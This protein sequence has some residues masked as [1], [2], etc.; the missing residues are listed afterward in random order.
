MGQASSLVLRDVHLAL[1]SVVEEAYGH[2]RTPS[3][4]DRWPTRAAR[5]IINQSRDVEAHAVEHAWQLKESAGEYALLHSFQRIAILQ[6]LIQLVVSTDMLREIM[7]HRIVTARQKVEA[8]LRMAQQERELKARQAAQE[9]EARARAIAN[10]RMALARAAQDEDFEGRMELGGEGDGG[11]SYVYSLS[12]A[13]PILPPPSVSAQSLAA[14]GEDSET[15]E[16]IPTKPMD[17]G[18]WV[19]MH[20]RLPGQP[21]GRDGLRR[22]YWLL[23]SPESGERIYVEGADGVFKGYYPRSSLGAL[24]D[25]MD[26]DAPVVPPEDSEETPADETAANVPSLDK[27]KR[28][29]LWDAA[30]MPGMP[31]DGD[32]VR[33]IGGE[34]EL[35]ARLRLLIGL[36]QIPLTKEVSNK[37]PEQ[38]ETAHEEMDQLQNQAANVD[39]L[40]NID[41]AKPSNLPLAVSGADAM[42]VDAAPVPSSTGLERGSS[43]P[44]GVHEVCAVPVIS[45]PQVDRYAKPSGEEKLEEDPY[46]KRNAPMFLGVDETAADT[47]MEMMKI[48]VEALL[49]TMPF[50]L[51][52]KAG[53]DIM[54]NT[55]VMLN[56]AETPTQ[57]GA[58]I[59]ITETLLQMSGCMGETW[60]HH[61]AAQWRLTLPMCT[62]PVLIA[63]AVVQ[64][65][66]HM[67]IPDDWLSRKGFARL[68]IES[69]CSH[70]HV[71]KL[72]DEVV[73]LRRGYIQHREAYAVAVPSLPSM[74]S[75]APTERFRVEGMAF[76]RTRMT[77]AHGE[78]TAPLQCWLL[79]CQLV[80]T[81][82]TAA[83]E[84]QAHIAANSSEG[85]VA[86]TGTASLRRVCVPLHLE[87]SL[88]EYI[89]PA[90]VFDSSMERSWEDGDMFKM[91]F[92]TG[93][94]ADGNATGCFYKGKVVRVDPARDP[95]GRKDPWESVVVSWASEDFRVSDESSC[96]RIS[97]WEMELDEAEMQRVQKER[98]AEIMKDTADAQIKEQAQAAELQMTMAMQL[99]QQQ[100]LFMT[101]GSVATP[102]PPLATSATKVPK[103]PKTSGIPLYP[104]RSTP[105]DQKSRRAV[106]QEKGTTRGANGRVAVPDEAAFMDSLEEFTNKQGFKFRVPT[107]CHVPLNMH[108]VFASVQQRGG[109]NIVTENKQWKDVC[110]MLDLDL[111]GQTSASF[112]MRN[113]YERMLLPFECHLESIH[114]TISGPDEGNPY[115]N[116][117]VQANGAEEAVGG[118]EHSGDDNPVPAGDGNGAG[119]LSTEP[120]AATSSTPVGPSATD[121]NG[122]DITPA[123]KL[124]EAAGA[125]TEQ[126]SDAAVEP[127]TLATPASD[128]LDGA[129]Q[130]AGEGRDVGEVVEAVPPMADD[131]AQDQRETSTASVKVDLEV[132][133]KGQSEVNDAADTTDECAV[134]PGGSGI[135]I[136]LKLGGSFASADSADGVDEGVEPE[137]VTVPADSLGASGVRPQR[138]KVVRSGAE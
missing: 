104:N 130:A 61:L 135:K 31:R 71:P 50:W 79:V 125:P 19:A 54:G 121:L 36:P 86:A 70:F 35:V 25:W 23:G 116:D 46:R 44:Q 115:H 5:A 123:P 126:E 52:R 82:R 13:A 106:R 16:I 62:T 127:H 2:E 99:A 22:R 103:D 27:S 89:I 40:A 45:M 11:Y 77:Q 80:A 118:D 134:T 83:A 56:A 51:W 65:Q 102:P 131:R 26:P 47:G 87:D 38:S 78:E 57:L 94:D 117:N 17:W 42:D 114:G 93:E 108:R 81:P 20:M 120:A 6:A 10:E 53:L 95:D 73:L 96:D 136:R 105:G 32:D 101:P 29:K 30:I 66:S 21:L 133:A 64:L 41:E 75:L 9:R 92:A 110:R 122:G 34:Q 8:T 88:P 24:L 138:I 33:F 48:C 119:D 60:T 97:P 100:Q 63:Q 28:E 4:Q 129:V 49:G 84:I 74:D 107:F 59:S 76:R 112:S 1:V 113:I 12:D 43:N 137:E 67:N 68:A 14:Q 85:G 72:G 58:V 111:T 69:G 55:T 91:Y 18:T 109:Y 3:R 37:S 39:D 15:T 132:L 98:E 7:N 128:A 124:S 90:K